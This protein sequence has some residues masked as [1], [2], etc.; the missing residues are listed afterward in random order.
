MSLVSLLKEKCGSVLFYSRCHLAVSILFLS[1]LNIATASSSPNNDCSGYFLTGWKLIRREIFKKEFPIWN[2]NSQPW[3][4][5]W[6]SGNLLVSFCL[7]G[8]FCHERFSSPEDRFFSEPVLPHVHLRQRLR[9]SRSICHDHT[10]R[11]TSS[12]LQNHFTLSS[13]NFWRTNLF[14]AFHF[15]VT[16][17]LLPRINM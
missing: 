13:D 14:Q 6:I 3:H 8:R 1:Q 15:D 16:L 9:Q 5:V 11:N 4:S 17:S 12:S 7:C 2:F 10:V